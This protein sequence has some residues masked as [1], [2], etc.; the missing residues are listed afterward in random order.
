MR[1]LD[2]ALSLMKIIQ[3]MNKILTI[4]NLVMDSHFN[5][6]G[7]P[8]CDIRLAAR[9]KPWFDARLIYWYRSGT[10]LMLEDFSNN[11]RYINSYGDGELSNLSFF[12]E[13]PKKK[14]YGPIN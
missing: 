2:L 8:G 12:L 4:F 10:F 14:I 6:S 1:I 5:E 7:T 13:T 11:I 3:T 9:Y